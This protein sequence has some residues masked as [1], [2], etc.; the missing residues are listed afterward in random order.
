MAEEMKEGLFITFEGP[1]GSGK[2]TQSRRLFDD[3]AGKGHD[4][5]YT[6]E[7]GGTALGE[8]IRSI[9]LDKDS[10]RL[11]KKAELFLFE[12]DRTQHVEQLILPALNSGKIVICDRFNTATFAYQGYGLDMD[13]EIIKTLDDIAVSGLVP[14]LILLMDIDVETGLGR[15]GKGGSADRVEKRDLEF[16]EKVRQGYLSLAKEDQETIKVIEVT[17]DIDQTYNLVKDVVNSVIERHTRSG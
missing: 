2:S 6:A 15:A 11:G 4:V 12:A 7:P 10:V 1:E 14:D 16:H 9:I 13:K 3:L 17:E 8:C 5:I